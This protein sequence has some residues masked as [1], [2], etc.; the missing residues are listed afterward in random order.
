MSGP[1]PTIQGVLEAYGAPAPVDDAEREFDRLM[2][3]MQTLIQLKPGDVLTQELIDDLHLV[4]KHNRE[5]QE[6]ATDAFSR[7]YD[8]GLERGAG[9]DTAKLIEDRDAARARVSIVNAL[10]SARERSRFIRG[11]QV[12]R[13]MMARF[14]EQG[15]HPVIAQS[16][17]L[18]W[19]PAWGDDP[20][21]PNEEDFGSATPAEIDATNGSVPSHEILET[22]WQYRDDLRHPPEGDSRDRR[23]ERVQAVL[24][25]LAQSEVSA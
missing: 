5:D 6:R 2:D 23:L 22:L 25:K 3:A 9:A 15:G 14:V 12:C 19:R 21:A 17:R 10:S 13:E 7:G 20:G 1:H 16:I 11:A 4:D 24:A 8:C 18:N